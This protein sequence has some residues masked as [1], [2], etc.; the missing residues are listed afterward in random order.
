MAWTTSVRCAFVKSTTPSIRDDPL[1]LAVN[2]PVLV[3]HPPLH[4][5]HVRVRAI[6]AKGPR[7][8]GLQQQQG[9][10]D[11]TQHPPRHHDVAR[12]HRAPTVDKSSKNLM[13]TGGRADQSQP[14]DGTLRS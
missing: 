13:W 6:I 5:P 10:G 7:P 1:L 2:P 11:R 4:I 3:V 8:S 9:R 14:D 12:V